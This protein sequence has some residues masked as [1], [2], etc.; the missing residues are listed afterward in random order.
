L[1]RIALMQLCFGIHPSTFAVVRIWATCDGSYSIGGA[2]YSN[3]HNLSVEQGAG[4]ERGITDG[5]C[6]MMHQ[7]NDTK[8]IEDMLEEKAAKMKAVA[9]AVKPA[10]GRN[11]TSLGHLA[12]TAGKSLSVKLPRPWQIILSA[13]PARLV[14]KNGTPSR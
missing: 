8:G 3:Q 1:R 5:I 11:H 6:V 13:L 2:S 4:L 12:R 7:V 9:T 10:L 14:S